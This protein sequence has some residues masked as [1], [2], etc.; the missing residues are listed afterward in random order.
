MSKK[1]DDMPEDLITITEAAS[2]RGVQVAAISKLI[3]RGRITGYQK[4]GKTLVSL[5]EIKKY[6][7]GTPGRKPQKGSKK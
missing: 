5:S 2:V 6:R 4:Y 7:P 1:R 3:E